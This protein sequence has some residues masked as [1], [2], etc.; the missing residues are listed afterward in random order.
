MSFHQAEWKSE[1]VWDAFTW[2]E[3]GLALEVQAPCDRGAELRN[4]RR[5]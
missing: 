4:P 5:F 2:T 1:L 3:A